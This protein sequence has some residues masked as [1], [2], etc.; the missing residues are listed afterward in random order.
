MKVA[1]VTL[2]IGEKY[3]NNFNLFIRSGWE[4]YCKKIG[5]DL[6]V[7]E[8]NL[9]ESDRGKSR[10]AAWQKLLILSQEWSAQYDRIIWADSD[11]IINTE[12]A[13]DI[14]KGVPIELVG[15][16][17]EFSTPSKEFHDIALARLRTIWN[18]YK[19]A[20]LEDDTPGTYYTSR[21]ISGGH[22]NAVVQTG[23]MVLS[24]KYHREVFERTY[25]NYGDVNGNIWN[26]EMPALSYELLTANLVHWISPRYN[27]LVIYAM[28]AFYRGVAIQ[29]NTHPALNLFYK[30]AHKVFGYRPKQKPNPIEL[31]IL[32]NIYDLSMFMHF[33]GYADTIPK[34]AGIIKG[35]R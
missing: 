10:S 25:Y 28:E 34:M 13:E 32:K 31:R 7:I 35:D 11:I 26:Y 21:N 2:I 29:N 30:V 33:A 9:D 17:D 5:F 1:L 6:V 16:C 18:T 20:I 4:L 22:L 8:H 15:A 23:V 12:T 3:V 19:I 14:T 27:F 24:P